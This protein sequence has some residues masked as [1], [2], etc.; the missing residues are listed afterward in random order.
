MF[1]RGVLAIGDREFEAVDSFHVGVERRAVF[2][3]EKV[4][5]RYKDVAEAHA[6][7]EAGHDQ[8]LHSFGGLGVGEFKAG[9]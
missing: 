8:R 5:P 7:Q 4:Y 2:M 6:D 1:G 3:D 9:D